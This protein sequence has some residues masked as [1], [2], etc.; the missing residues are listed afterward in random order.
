MRLVPADTDTIPPWMVAFIRYAPGGAINLVECAGTL[1]H[2][3]W[4]LTAAHAVIDPNTTTAVIGRNPLMSDKG[5]MSLIKR[6]VV[7]PGYNPQLTPPPF[8]LAL[9][10][11]TA[12]VVPP[13]LPFSTRPS[14][15]R[16][17]D[18]DD[19]SP[20]GQVFGWGET[21]G[22]T[23]LFTNCMKQI[24]VTVEKPASS[25]PDTYCA[26]AASALTICYGDSG[27][28]LL[29]HSGGFWLQIGITSSLTVAREC[30]TRGIYTGVAANAEWIKEVLGS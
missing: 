17:S 20:L 30:R 4:V 18:G 26:E 29:I 21:S 7:N 5:Q 23:G 12:P 1:V 10:E 2:P 22:K 24:A 28:P 16:L 19:F 11:L 27:G 14:Y 3:K 13:S 25:P 8:D 9:V 15:V 6:V